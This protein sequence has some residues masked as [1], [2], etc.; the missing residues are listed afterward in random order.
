MS[1]WLSDSLLS[2]SD[3]Q[4]NNKSYFKNVIECVKLFQ[5]NKYHNFTG[6][7]VSAC[8]HRCIRI[9]SVT[10]IKHIGPV[11][12]T[13]SGF[14]SLY[15]LH[16]HSKC[17]RNVRL[18]HDALHHLVVEPPPCWREAALQDIHQPSGLHLV[19]TT[20]TV[21]SS[22]ATRYWW[23]LRQHGEGWRKYLLL[24]SSFVDKADKL[25]S[26]ILQSNFQCEPPP[27]S[28]VAFYNRLSEILFRSWV[29]FI[30]FN[31]NSNNSNH[32]YLYSYRDIFPHYC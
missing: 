13:T 7:D 19:G 24:F 20:T 3:I 8:C 9:L 28:L 18:L 25:Y 22:A 30:V 12:F 11:T 23:M 21:S 2:S 16:L 4:R 15:S 29:Y 1:S 26:V 5:Q 27:A 32:L 31:F 10:F 14:S 17:L 6:K